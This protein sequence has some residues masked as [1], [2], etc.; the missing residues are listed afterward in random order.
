MISGSGAGSDPR[1][2][3]ALSGAWPPGE[4]TQHTTTHHNSLPASCTNSS[5]LCIGA[6]I[7]AVTQR[8]PRR[9]PGTR[10]AAAQR[11]PPR[12]RPRHPAPAGQCSLQDAE[13]EDRLQ[14]AHHDPIGQEAGHL[15]TLRP[16]PVSHFCQLNSSGASVLQARRRA[17]ERGRQPAAAAAATAA[18][19]PPPPARPPRPATTWS[20]CSSS[21]ASGVPVAFR[22]AAYCAT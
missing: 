21:L 16:R 20:S 13:C 18:A 19:T 10:A 15:A 6:V 22:A 4:P 11:A 3:R 14:G 2:A 12:R 8:A 9:G 5:T 1:G 17:R 7:P